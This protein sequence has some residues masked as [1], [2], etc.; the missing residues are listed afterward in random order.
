MLEVRRGLTY[1]DAA[2]GALRYDFTA[3]VRTAERAVSD[4]RTLLGCR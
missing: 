2:K 1:A 4:H 3:A